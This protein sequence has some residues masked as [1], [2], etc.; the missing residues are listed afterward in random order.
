[1][2]GK[3][4]AL[5]I[6]SLALGATSVYAQERDESKMNELSARPIDDHDVM[7]KRTLWRRMDLNEKQNLPMFS[8]NNEITR[9]LLEATKAGLLD[10]Y[11]NDSCTTKLTPEILRKKLLIPNQEG[12]LS[13]EEIAAGFG[14]P[15]TTGGGWDDPAPKAAAKTE[16]EDDG[17]GAPKKD[18]KK[19][20]AVEDDG[21]GPPVKK[22]TSKTPAKK[23]AKTEVAAAEPVVEEQKPDEFSQQLSTLVPEEE[24]YPN[25][26]SIMEV[27]ED[28]TFDKKRSRLY[29]D[30]QTL[31]IYLPADQNTSTG[32][33]IPIASFK[34]K[35]VERLFRS[36]SKKYIW[37][38]TQNVAQHKNLADAF[39]LR[40]PYGRITKYSNPEDKSFIDIY[41]GEKQGLMKSAQ[42]EQEL[43][44][45]E[46]GLWEY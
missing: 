23:G 46:H 16:T 13:A 4:V 8:K 24:F 10:A 33:E 25:Q 18:T 41:K 12:G 15:A 21:W 20:A 35:D 45:L 26:L 29:M 27:K 11:E 32:L 37:Y 7:M 31:T 6:V 14:Q 39:D 38:N 34:Y 1:M 42:Y 30:I 28:W 19:T 22:T 36:D 44:E 5:S 43:L 9:Y 40:L 17:W 3:V 2:N